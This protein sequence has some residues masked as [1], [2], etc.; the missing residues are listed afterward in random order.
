MAVGQFSQGT[1]GSCPAGSNSSPAAGCPDGYRSLS[2]TS[3]AATWQ[4]GITVWRNNNYTP[5]FDTGYQYRL[6]PLVSASMVVDS[7]TSPA[8]LWSQ[9]SPILQTSVFAFAARGSSWTLSPVGSPTKCLD[10]GA[11]GNGT[12]IAVNSCNGSASQN[13]NI[14]A[15]PQSG[16]FTIAAALTGRCMHARNASSSP[17][18]VMEVYDCLAGNPSQQFNVQAM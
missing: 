1:S 2:T 14:G 10:A 6:S 7:G 4:H 3:N 13:W 11:G 16:A 18:T 8:Q 12:G 17:G 15:V 9:T 5:V